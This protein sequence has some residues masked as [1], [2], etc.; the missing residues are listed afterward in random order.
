M[1]GIHLFILFLLLGEVSFAFNGIDIFSFDA[2]TEFLI[3]TL[4]GKVGC[5]V[6]GPFAGQKAIALHG[7]KR[8]LDDEWFVTAKALA[9]LGI[10]VYVLNMH[11]LPREYTPSK[12][13]SADF[14]PIMAD[15][16]HHIAN[17]SEGEKVA[18]MGKSWGASMLAYYANSQSSQISSLTLVAPV[19]GPIST[20][21]MMELQR[22]TGFLQ[23]MLM[24]NL[25]DP[26][27]GILR[28][29]KRVFGDQ[30]KIVYNETGGHRIIKEFTLPIHSFIAST[31]LLPAPES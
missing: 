14:T 6:Y 28:R 1:T 7:R 13:K 26:L 10:R 19:I 21:E 22:K 2:G 23:I 17:A 16:V 8:S 24:Y 27:N 31:K 30:V 3:G 4:H 12:I 9:R 25:D 15:V 29:W 18:L 11:T 20:K 5:K